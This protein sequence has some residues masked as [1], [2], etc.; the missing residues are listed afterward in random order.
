MGKRGII[1][2][3]LFLW[4]LYIGFE[5]EY[6]HI[7][8]KTM[9]SLSHFLIYY[10]LNI[11]LFYLNSLVVLNYAFFRTGRPY[12]IYLLL[13]IPEVALYMGVKVLL[14]ALLSEPPVSVLQVVQWGKVYFMANLWRGINFIGLS[15]AY[16]ST[17]Y[18][19]RFK[20]RNHQAETERLKAVTARLELENRY[21]S[22]ENAYLQNQISPHLLFNT[23]N[24]V[25]ASVEEISEKAAKGIRYLS[26]LMRYS[27]VSTGDQQKVPLAAEVK[28]IDNLVALTRLR[29]GDDLYLE[30]TRTGEITDQAVMPLLLVTLVENML[31][32]GDLGEQAFPAKLDLKIFPGSLQF[33][34]AN[35]KRPAA[36]Y[37]QSGIGLKNLEKRLENFYPGRYK[38]LIDDR[39]DIFTVTLNLDL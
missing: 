19:I 22:V 12:L 15:I 10:M 4:I 2:R 7:T 26:E 14:D 8:V 25:Y 28:Q 11:G 33:V 31:K 37:L 21:I 36:P 34:A 18:M 29:F 5:V 39:F 16:F 3:H 32:H 6:L 13:L 27:L 17:I 30:F 20:D 38:L 24:F 1:L 9:A 35:R 23:L